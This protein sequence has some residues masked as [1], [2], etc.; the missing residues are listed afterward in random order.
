MVQQQKLFETMEG[1]IP[2]I[3]QAKEMMSGID[4]SQ[5]GGLAD[6]ANGLGVQG[7]KPK[8]NQ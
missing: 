6:M 8:Q 5:L 4:M 1:M 7:Q 3:H 2:M